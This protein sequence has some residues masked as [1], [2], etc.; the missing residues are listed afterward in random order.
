MES[1]AG[2]EASEPVTP[3][4]DGSEEEVPT[5][6]RLY[7]TV[8]KELGGSAYKGHCNF[9]PWKSDSTSSFRVICH[10]G[11][12]E[13]QGV[14]ICPNVPDR[15]CAAMKTHSKKGK[16]G[17]ADQGV[18][19]PGLS[20]GVG[21]ASQASLSGS[22]G[23]ARKRQYRQGTITAG[24]TNASKEETDA[25][26]A[27]F[28]YATGISFNVLASPYWQAAA[29]AIARHGKLNSGMYKVPTVRRLRTKAL[30]AE[31]DRVQ[32]VMEELR[33]LPDYG[34]TICCDG[35]TS[36]QGV[37]YMNFVCVHMNGMEFLFAENCTDVE[38]KTGLYIGN[39]LLKAIDMVGSSR[40]VQVCTDNA[41]NMLSAGKV[42][43]DKYPHITHT[44]CTSHCLDLLLE[45]WGDVEECKELCEDAASIIRLIGRYGALKR[46]FRRHSI[47]TC[48]G[49]EL[50]RPAAT[51]FGT[52]FMVLER[53]KQLR[54][55]LRMTAA[56]PE[57]DVAVARS[58][59]QRAGGLAVKLSGRHFWDRIDF[60]LDVMEPVFGL[61][62]LTDG[63]GPCSGKVYWKMWNIREQLK[64]VFGGQGR[65]RRAAA[66]G[67]GDDLEDWM[68]SE[69]VP[70][71]APMDEGTLA[72]FWSERWEGMHSPIHGASY[73]LDP[74]HKEDDWH[75]NQEVMEDFEIMTGK[76]LG[77][78]KIGEAK[79][80][81]LQW[82]LA[83]L[84][85]EKKKAAKEMFGHEWWTLN[86]AAWPL[87]MV[88]AMKLLPLCSS[89]TSCERVWSTYTFIGS[90]RRASLH[91]ER[92]SDLVYCYT[93]LKLIER[94]EAGF[95]KVAPDWWKP[96]GDDNEADDEADVVA[97]DDVCVS[98]PSDEDAW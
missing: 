84:N 49:K 70:E 87:L 94:S 20:G 61:L 1:G 16:E 33:G 64:G 18:S 22:S 80:Q 82:R 85:D 88:L 90:A 48:G 25:M 58:S 28:C 97:Q 75:K 54:P 57:W 5:D 24:L 36:K 96:L 41:A 69:E 63:E 73:P 53:I 92:L 35:Y 7:F 71:T 19:I 95:S 37:Q 46:V 17:F 72:A 43:M 86:G 66:G 4:Q 62:R 12:I 98:E 14:R 83:P 93:N 9:C 10:L 77:T 26:V 3:R 45:D 6:F 31:K 51:R 60:F 59:D 29:S 56:H 50:V 34:M 39:L 44:P 68:E 13:K 23:A 42:V 32:K 74:E 47:E 78:D 52:Q 76:L 91:P 2:G 11:R 8:E 30:L 38:K 65:R 40:V 79:K 27:R 81:L 21:S 89:A 55:A 67:E 15:V